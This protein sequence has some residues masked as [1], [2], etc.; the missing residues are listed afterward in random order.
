MSV[1]RS[2]VSRGRTWVVHDTGRTVR[3]S[4]WRADLRSWMLIVR[5]IAHVTRRA[6]VAHWRRTAHR[7]ILM[8]IWMWLRWL[9]GILDGDYLL[10]R[11]I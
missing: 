1:L 8:R 4:V 9:M 7:R 3:R 2:E 5:L 11:M 10:S 6:R